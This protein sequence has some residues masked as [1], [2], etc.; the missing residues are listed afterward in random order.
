L[1]GDRDRGR[2]RLWQVPRHGKRR[3]I[4][5]RFGAHHSNLPGQRFP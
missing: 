4:P 3:L 1:R 2:R 5:W